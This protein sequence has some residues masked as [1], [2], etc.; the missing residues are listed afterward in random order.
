MVEC[1]SATETERKDGGARS[2]KIE[3]QKR[4]YKAQT[5]QEILELKSVKRSRTI[6]LKTKVKE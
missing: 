2:L 1:K 6:P 3:Q 5:S 4:K